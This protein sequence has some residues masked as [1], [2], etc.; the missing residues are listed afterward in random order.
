MTL[1]AAS[2]WSWS[3]PLGRRAPRVASSSLRAIMMS[4]AAQ[5]S[6]RAPLLPK[7]IDWTGTATQSMRSHSVL[8]APPQLPASFTVLGIE[9]SCDD[10]GVAVVR[11]DGTI[12]GESI[13]S[14]A[15][16]HEEW[17]G[18]MPGIARDAHAEALNRTIAEALDRAG[19]QSVA[20]VD[21]V[22]VTVGPGLEICLRVGT[23]AAKALALR[24]AASDQA[25]SAEEQAAEAEAAKAEMEAAV[26]RA[27]AEAAQA[28]EARDLEAERAATAETGQ[29]QTAS[30]LNATGA[31]TQPQP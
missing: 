18:V 8:A 5:G 16:L 13:A 20:D 27:K 12:L 22:A 15:E 23:E 3:P 9:T 6:K 14:Q 1:L 26:V 21:A 30:Q 2:A 31:A 28:K 29:R 11:C 17:G 19:L 10:T 24:D 7:S 4:A 25:A